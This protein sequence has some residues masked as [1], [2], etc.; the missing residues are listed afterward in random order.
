LELSQGR[1]FAKE[2]GIPMASNLLD[3]CLRM[4]NG[5]AKDKRERE[6]E[7][8]YKVARGN[9]GGRDLHIVGTDLNPLIIPGTS[10]D[11]DA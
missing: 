4:P 5:N 9:C 1:D 6:R 8:E 11:D 3:P 7:R 10:A 2:L